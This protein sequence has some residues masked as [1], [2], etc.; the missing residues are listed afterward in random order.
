MN[1]AKIIFTLCTIYIFSNKMPL[2]QEKSFKGADGLNGFTHL[3]NF[4]CLIKLCIAACLTESVT[5][6]QMFAPDG[7]GL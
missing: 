1:R 2:L 4:P 3:V 5:H 6:F 7:A